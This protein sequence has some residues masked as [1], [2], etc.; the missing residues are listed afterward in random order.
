MH[1]VAVAELCCISMPVS[2]AMLHEELR[3]DDVGHCD[4]FQ[5]GMALN[6]VKWFEKDGV[7]CPLP[8]VPALGLFIKFWCFCIAPKHWNFF[9]RWGLAQGC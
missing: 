3:V 1:V 2:V 8:K 7:L 6:D 9:G 5:E 4:L